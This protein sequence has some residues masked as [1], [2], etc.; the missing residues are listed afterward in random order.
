MVANQWNVQEQREEFAGDKKQDIEK[1][2]ENVL[3]Q[4]QWIQRITLINGI[5]VISFKLVKSDDLK[6]NGSIQD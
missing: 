2:V 1:S 3:R 4:N 5:F 6:W